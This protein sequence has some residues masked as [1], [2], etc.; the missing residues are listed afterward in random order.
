MG[1]CA[2]K[3]GGSEDDFVQF[4]W[5]TISSESGALSFTQGG[6]TSLTIF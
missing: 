6:G 3:H 2:Q 5:V 1:R 4:F